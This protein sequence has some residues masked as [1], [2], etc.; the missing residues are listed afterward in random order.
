LSSVEIIRANTIDPR[1]VAFDGTGGPRQGEPGVDGRSIRLDAA[2]QAHERT[3]SAV[4]CLLEPRVEI[5]HALPH[6]QAAKALQQLVAGGDAF[7]VRKDVFE[8]FTF[9][10]IELVR[11][12]QT[13]PANV[14]PPCSGRPASPWTARDGVG[15]WPRS[16]PRDQCSI[17]Q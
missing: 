4:G 2:G 15:R 14:G 6:D 17:Q 8:R 16:T 13:Q 12:T 10:L 11:R 9:V 7:V 3:K 1:N 5:T